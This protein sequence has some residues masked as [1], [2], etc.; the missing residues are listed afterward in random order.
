MFRC[1]KCWKK[2]GGENSTHCYIT[3]CSHMFCLDCGKAHFQKNTTCPGCDKDVRGEGEVQLVD[4]NPSDQFRS[5]SLCGLDPET[6]M[7]MAARGLAFYSYQKQNEIAYLSFLNRKAQQ[8]MT[9]MQRQFEEKLSKG[10][11]ALIALKTQIKQL[12]E[13]ITSG[14]KDYK[15]LEEKFAEKVKQKRKLEEMM[16]ILKAKMSAFSRTHQIHPSMTMSPTLSRTSTPFGPMRSLSPSSTPRR[17]LSPS[18]TPRYSSSPAPSS[19]SRSHS[20]P[21]QSPSLPLGGISSSPATRLSLHT[22]SI[23]SP[24]S[25]SVSSSSS[26]SSSSSALSSYPLPSAIPARSRTPSRPS[27]ARPP[28]SPFIASDLGIPPSSTPFV[29]PASKDP[30]TRL[31]E[32]TSRGHLHAPDTPNFL[33]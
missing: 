24:R 14:K 20:N 13:E 4:L 17:S 23:H 31:K 26:S 6:I 9:E 18:S 15:E 29:L 12:T 32:T 33:H 27:S 16:D 19:S 10:N 5:M 21:T 30:W 8:K 7:E 22:P 11:Q 2:L 3:I 25:S 1:N 28:L